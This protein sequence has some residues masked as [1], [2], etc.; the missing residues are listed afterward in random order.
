MDPFSWLVCMCILVTVQSLHT[1]HFLYG[2][3]V[4]LS[5]GVTS[6]QQFQ[7]CSCSAFTSVFGWFLTVSY[8]VSTNLEVWWSFETRDVWRRFPYSV[9]HLRRRRACRVIHWGRFSC[10]AGLGPVMLTGPRLTVSN[11]THKLKCRST[12]SLSVRFK[13]TDLADTNRTHPQLVY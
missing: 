6:S 1:F 10:S 3:L 5:S 7:S 2:I 8:S 9:L 12:S 11:T 4:I 13:S